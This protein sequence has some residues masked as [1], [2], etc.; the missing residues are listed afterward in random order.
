MRK[1][2]KLLSS[3]LFAYLLIVTGVCVGLFAIGLFV[4]QNRVEPKPPRGALQSP[5][6]PSAKKL[7]PAAVN[8]YSVPPDN[9]KYIAIPAI[10]IPNTPVLLLGLLKNGQIATPNNVFE[11]G[12]Y[13]GSSRPG[14]PGAMFIYGHVSSWA[15]DGIFYNLKKLV[16]GDTV[17][18]TRGDNEKFVYRVVTSKVYPYNNVNMNQVLSPINADQPGLNLMTCT[19]QVIQGTS[20]FNKRLVIFTTLVS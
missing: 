11:T 15:A 7:T 19:G 6:A 8:T 3:R 18:I 9:P 20:E 12:W 10:N 4:H 17:T 13:D 14:E 1:M 16:P 2:R 5:S